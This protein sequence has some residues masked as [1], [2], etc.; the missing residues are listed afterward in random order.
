MPPGTSAC[1]DIPENL[2]QSHI[3]DRNVICTVSLRTIATTSW[4]DAGFE[5][6]WKQFSVPPEA[7]SSA[8]QPLTA[9]VCPKLE[10]VKHTIRLSNINFTLDF[11]KAQAKIVR[12]TIRG[13]D[14]FDSAEGPELTFWR[15]PTDNDIPHDAKMWKLFGVDA[16]QK[17]VRSLK[18]SFKD[19]V[20][21]IVVESYHSPPILAWGFDVFTIYT[22]F[23]DGDVQ[24]HVHAEPRGAM[25]AVLPRFGLEMGLN[26]KIKSV[27]WF[28]K[29]PGESYNDKKEAARF[30]IW[31]KTVD[32]MPFNYEYPQ[33]NGS[34]LR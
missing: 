6:A 10:N 24:I 7:R 32:E 31:D 5:V 4:A 13:H 34:T 16:M 9:L 28:G 14:V 27:K 11:D 29:G 21:K 26:K 15:A 20:F 3:D 19:G 2:W 8:V 18:Y 30:G 17:Q 1:M 22:I 33:E 23:G 25:P 12:W